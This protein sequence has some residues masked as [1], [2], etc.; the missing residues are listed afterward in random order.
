MDLLFVKIRVIRGRLL[1]FLF[2]KSIF[3]SGEQS[4]DVG[5]VAIDGESAK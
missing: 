2:P 1:F 5:A 4:L 3:G